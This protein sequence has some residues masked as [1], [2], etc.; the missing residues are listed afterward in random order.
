M[1]AYL[2]PMVGIGLGVVVAS[3]P[4]SLQMVVG[5]A[6]IIGGVALV[7]A[8]IGQRRLFGRRAVAGGHVG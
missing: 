4:I 6:L 5:S 7:N 2:M 1:V 3:E 8:R